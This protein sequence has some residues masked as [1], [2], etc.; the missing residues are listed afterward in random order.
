MFDELMNYINEQINI[1]NAEI[2]QGFYSPVGSPEHAKRQVLHDAELVG[3]QDAL[4][5]IRKIDK[6][7]FSKIAGYVDIEIDNIN[8]E[9]EN[10]NR[11]AITSVE[12]KKNIEFMSH[13]LNG[14]LS[15]YMGVHSKV[16]EILDKYDDKNIK[17]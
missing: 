16:Y 17:L 1:T 12:D 8:N 14:A 4:Y 15:A 5:S 10:V 9:I 11:R 6:P 2:K 3:T 7:S 13:G